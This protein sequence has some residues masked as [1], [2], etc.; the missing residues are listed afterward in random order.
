MQQLKLGLW[1]AD[2]SLELQSRLI[3]LMTYCQF[4][5]FNPSTTPCKYACFWSDRRAEIPHEVLSMAATY[6]RRLTGMSVRSAEYEL[7][8]IAH[9]EVPAFGVYFYEIIDMFG[10]RMLMGVGPE[11]VALCRMDS[12]FIDR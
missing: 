8:R 4:G 11:Y 3:A 9:E 5:G 7:L 1:D 10:S 2:T 12:T 6:H